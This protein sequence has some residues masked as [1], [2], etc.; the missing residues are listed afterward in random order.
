MF[1]GLIAAG[2][3]GSLAREL[4]WEQNGNDPLTSLV[5]GAIAGFVVGLAYL[6][7]QWV[8]AP[9]VL[10]AEVIKPTDKIQFASAVLVALPA[11]V[12]F[13][14]VFERL[15]KEARTGPITPSR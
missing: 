4:L 3:T 1:L 2:A 11:G 7:P 6:I 12:G 13:N 9:D 10:K 15:R 5:L 14:T 8:G